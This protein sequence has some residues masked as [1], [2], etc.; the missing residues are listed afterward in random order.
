MNTFS[1]TPV[2]CNAPC[3]THTTWHTRLIPALLTV[4]WSLCTPTSGTAQTQLGTDIG[5]E[6]AGDRSGYSVSL[7]TDGDILAVSAHTNDGGGEDAG[8]VR[9]YQWTDSAWLQLGHDINGE[10]AGD[11]AGGDDSISL[12]ADGHKLAIGADRNDGNGTDS[13]HA[14]VYQWNGQAWQQLGNDIDGGAAEDQFGESVSLSADGNRLA[15]GAAYA[16]EPLT[17]QYIG[18][19]TT[20]GGIDGTGQVRVYQWTGTEWA[21]LG[22]DID[23]EA[24]GDVSG[25]SVSLSADGSRLAV[26]AIRNDGNGENSGHVRVFE[27]T[28]SSWQQVGADI[29]GEAAGDY[30]G[31]SVSLSADG[32]RFA[33]GAWRNSPAGHVRVFDW[34]GIDWVQV[35][36][37]IDGEGASDYFG[38]SVSLSASGG[39]LVVG[40]AYNDDAGDNA[41][42]ARVYQWSG[43][44][45][46]QLG[47][48]IDGKAADDKFGHAVALS[49]DG[50]RVAIGAINNDD[51]GFDSGHTR[52][53]D[54]SEF[55]V[56]QINPGLNDAWYY[57]TTDGQ[58]FFINVFP[59]LGKVA[60]SWFTYDTEQPSEG[61]TANLGDPG[62][63][64]L[65][66]LGRYYDN[67]AV[68]N[69]KIAS[70]G[71][72]D[73]PAAEAEVIRVLD[74]TI[75]LT[76]DSCNS[77]TVEY[78]IPSIDRTGVIPIQRVVDDNIALCEAFNSY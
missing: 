36:E 31:D 70:G 37:D 76:F 56:F 26:G 51:N 10:A 52:V 29:D 21:Q 34:T 8:H 25:W 32:T 1:D 46:T 17:L 55:N 43:G 33:A 62:H 57:P 22:T 47:F 54:F 78:D 59:D 74:G 28:G 11:K 9:V 45:W 42:H 16:N 19:P 15:V 40:A 75:I 58:G 5:G 53:Y 38:S 20:K 2:R 60:L 69:I 14:R 50:N 66:A 72:F 77:G 67:Q 41:G 68:M 7:S 44:A 27:W 18:P 63:R 64:W 73:T 12:S 35:G 6:A 23:G 4:I 61:V 49:G 30:F 24:T 39:R 65:N 48:D 13:G 71:L 3:S